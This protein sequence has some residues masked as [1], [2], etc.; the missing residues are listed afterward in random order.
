MIARPGFSANDAER[1]AGDA[2]ANYLNRALFI[3]AGRIGLEKSLGR[4]PAAF[5]SQ[6]APLLSALVEAQAREGN[7]PG[8]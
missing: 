1:Q 5:A 4:D 8:N 3:L 7:P 2:A 6:F